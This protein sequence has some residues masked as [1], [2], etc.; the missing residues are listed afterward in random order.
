MGS[1]SVSDTSVLSKR[2][3]ECNKESPTGE[4]FHQN[5][6]APSVTLGLEL[7]NKGHKDVVFLEERLEI[8]LQREVRKKREVQFSKEKK[9]T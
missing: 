9:W 2:Q 7:P 6:E 3:S 8:K 1:E 5:A 4:S